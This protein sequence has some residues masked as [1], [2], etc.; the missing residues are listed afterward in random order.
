MYS[1]KR[2]CFLRCFRPGT[3][4]HSGLCDWVTR[5]K[6]P[7]GT[8]FIHTRFYYSFRYRLYRL[9]LLTYLTLFLD[10]Y[11]AWLHTYR[12]YDIAWLHTF[13]YIFHVL[14]ILRAIPLQRA[15]GWVSTA[16]PRRS[17]C[18]K[19]ETIDTCR[20]SEYRTDHASSRYAK[21]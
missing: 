10:L 6:Q 13:Y 21:P 18:H 19:Q 9:I 17:L 20:H 16:P 12:I 8:S 15:R 1:K 11:I 7:K 14:P 3:K 4:E 2:S 5:R